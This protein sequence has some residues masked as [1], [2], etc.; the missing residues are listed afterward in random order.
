MGS[1]DFSALL[2]QGGWLNSKQGEGF[3]MNQVIG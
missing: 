3:D 2:L 1:I